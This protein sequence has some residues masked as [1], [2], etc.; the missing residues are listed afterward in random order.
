MRKHRVTSRADTYDAMQNKRKL[1]MKTKSKDKSISIACPL[2]VPV[3]SIV[4][5]GMNDIL[6]ERSPQLLCY[7]PHLE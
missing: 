5:S 1:A 6:P 7:L 3:E 4:D 2:L